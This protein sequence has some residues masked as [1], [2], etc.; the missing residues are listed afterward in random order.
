MLAVLQPWCTATQN[1]VD[2]NGTING[3]QINL[4]GSGIVTGACDGMNFS[5]TADST[6][7]LTRSGSSSARGIMDDK[8][9]ISEN[10][11]ILIDNHLRIFTIIAH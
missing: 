3:D 10:S 1:N 7:V 4:Q 6:A 11:L 5:C 2:T 8:E 9:V